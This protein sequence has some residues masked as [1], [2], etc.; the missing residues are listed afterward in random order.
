MSQRTR[1]IFSPI[2]STSTTTEKK[3]VQWTKYTHTQKMNNFFSTRTQS[4]KTE[5]K[6]WEFKTRSI[7]FKFYQ[8]FK[9]ITIQFYFKN[10]NET[11]WIFSFNQRIF[12]LDFHVEKKTTFKIECDRTIYAPKCSIIID[13]L[14]VKG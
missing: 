7:F 9:F 5:K 11:N 3:F 8:N 4:E 6:Y 14:S 1:N 12:V 2:W 13:I 10:A